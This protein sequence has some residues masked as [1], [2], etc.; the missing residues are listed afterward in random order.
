MLKD[1]IT[2]FKSKLFRLT[3]LI[4]LIRVFAASAQIVVRNTGQVFCVKM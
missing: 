2:V 3:P 1:Q 4:E